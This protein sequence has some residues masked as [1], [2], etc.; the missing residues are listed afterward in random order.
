MPVIPSLITRLR[1]IRRRAQLNR[2][3]E[4]EL[5]AHLALKQRYYEAQGLP[6]EE[7][8][9]R[10]HLA[11]GNATHWKERIAEEW[12][13]PRLES[14]WRDVAFGIRILLK[15]R[16]F[17]AVAVLTLTRHRRQYRGVLLLNSLLWRNLP[18]RR[19][20]NWSVFE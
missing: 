10:A 19:R 13:F 1:S 8:A 9:R 15:D 20:S 17:T 12:G 7:A 5:R 6:E 2:D 16:I 4:D 11:L 18:V 14:L 3:L